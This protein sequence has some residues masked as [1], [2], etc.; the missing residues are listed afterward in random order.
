VRIQQG[1]SE[2]APQA[3]GPPRPP[4]AKPDAEA[5]A[6]VIKEAQRDL[7]RAQ[8]ELEQ[9]K[10]QGQDDFQTGPKGERVLSAAYT[11]RV[12]TAQGKVEAARQQLERA[13]RP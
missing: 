7:I 3:A 5:R 8:A 10:I 1:P 11:N 6:K 4:A 12:D 2:H 9:A 13:R